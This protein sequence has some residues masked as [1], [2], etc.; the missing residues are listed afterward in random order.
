MSESLLLLNTL[1]PYELI[2]SPS[3]YCAVVHF[4]ISKT[5]LSTWNST[6]HLSS[7]PFSRCP[8]EWQHS[9]L[10]SQ[11]ELNNSEGLLCLCG[12]TLLQAVQLCHCCVTGIQ[13]CWVYITYVAL[14]PW[15]NFSGWDIC[16]S[17]LLLSTAHISISNTS[18]W[19]KARGLC[20]PPSY[21][22]VS[23]EKPGKLYYTEMSSVL[24]PPG[25]L[26]IEPHL[27]WR[28]RQNLLFTVTV[29]KLGKDL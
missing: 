24:L 5:A 7:Q 11:V 16:V 20:G 28:R 25:T 14:C 19:G 4:Y 21:A 2:T 22:L 12:C 26:G 10:I 8:Y 18:S 1:A 13:C 6:S 17:A 3:S 23:S 15:F 9:A 29:I 27:G